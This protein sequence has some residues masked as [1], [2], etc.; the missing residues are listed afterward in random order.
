MSPEPRVQAVPVFRP[1]KRN[2]RAAVRA[3][4]DMIS[5]PQD[6]FELTTVLSLSLGIDFFLIIFR[7][8]DATEVTGVYCWK[9]PACIRLWGT[10]KATLEE[11]Q[12]DTCYRFGPF[13]FRVLP[14]NRVSR[15]V[16]AVV[17]L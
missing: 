15:A 3:A 12:V 14:H 17:L 2:N 6:R 10:D 11:S 8:R 9:G 7:T 13:G 5:A 4:M 1:I 16:D